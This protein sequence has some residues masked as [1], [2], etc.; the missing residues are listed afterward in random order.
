MPQTRELSLQ[1]LP[2][3]GKCM[4]WPQLQSPQASWIFLDLPRVPSIFLDLQT[5]FRCNPTCW[6][7]KTAENGTMASDPLAPRCHRP[8]AQTDVF[9]VASSPRKCLLQL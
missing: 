3:Q 9:G 8:G 1:D 7:K 5:R 6:P 4:A 2:S